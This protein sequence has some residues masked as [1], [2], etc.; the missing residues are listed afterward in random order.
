M[1]CFWCEVFCVFQTI[2]PTAQL[3]KWTTNHRNNNKCG[4]WRIG[5]ANLRQSLFSIYLILSLAVVHS[6]AIDTVRLCA[7]MHLHEH[8]R[9]PYMMCEKIKIA[10]KEPNIDDMSETAHTFNSNE[11][12]TNRLTGRKRET[13]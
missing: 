7:F 13:E 1:N 9:L 2:Q 3:N 4:K 6:G 5:Y 12:K 11:T 10:L 8:F